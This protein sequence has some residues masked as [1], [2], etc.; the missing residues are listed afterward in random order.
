MTYLAYATTLLIAAV[1]VLSGTEKLVDATGVV[2]RGW[3]PS[4]VGRR[5]A[6]WGMRSVGVMEVLVGFVAAFPLGT[7]SI[8]SALAIVLGTSVTVYGLLALRNSKGCGCGAAVPSVSTPRE[9]LL[10]NGGFFGV[11]V[12]GTLTG[13]SHDAFRQDPAV[14]VLAATLGLYAAAAGSIACRAWRQSALGSAR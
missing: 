12:A 10:R 14:Y 5:A 1:L 8:T 2:E 3:A 4:F 7:R 11:L 13:P 6:A 9:L